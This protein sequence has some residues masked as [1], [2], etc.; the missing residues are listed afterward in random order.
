MPSER[1]R[2]YAAVR[3]QGHGEVLIH[4]SKRAIF[5]TIYTVATKKRR[6]KVNPDVT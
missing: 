2:A 1:A 6:H 3:M 4:F 5:C